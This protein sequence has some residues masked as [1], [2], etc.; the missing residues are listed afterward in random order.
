MEAREGIAIRKRSDIRRRLNR[1]F[2]SIDS[3][4][5]KGQCGASVSRPGSRSVRDELGMVVGTKEKKKFKE[6][7]RPANGPTFD[8]NSKPNSV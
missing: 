3:F 1:R 2:I 7:L 6:S 4:D 8:H 5:K